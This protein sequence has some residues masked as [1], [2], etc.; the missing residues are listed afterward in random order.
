M[1]EILDRL[2]ARLRANLIEARVFRT[3]EIESVVDRVRANFTNIND[4]RCFGDI[5]KGRVL[6]LEEKKAL[7]LNSRRKYAAEFI[8][9]FDTAKLA[10]TNPSE[11]FR[12]CYMD[13]VNHARSGAEFERMRALGIKTVKLLDPFSGNGCRAAKHGAREYPIDA[14]PSL[15]LPGCDQDYCRCIYIAKVPGFS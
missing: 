12:R 8:A 10:D 5:E 14:A 4:L 11:A 6:S 7:G 1:N 9:L 2:E 3:D 13:A 15:P